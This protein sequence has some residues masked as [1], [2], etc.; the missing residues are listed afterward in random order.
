MCA[1]ILH[2]DTFSRWI[3]F[4]TENVSVNC[5]RVRRKHSILTRIWKQQLVARVEIIK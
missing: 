1:K 5:V 2:S 4:N 3:Q